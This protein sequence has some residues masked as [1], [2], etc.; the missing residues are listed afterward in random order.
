MEYFITKHNQS[1]IVPYV[2]NCAWW[3]K[4]Y[5]QL[6][7]VVSTVREYNQGHRH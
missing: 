4:I 3:H 1:A 7:R 6:I 2:E 5:K